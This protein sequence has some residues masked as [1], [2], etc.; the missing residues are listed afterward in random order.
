MIDWIRHPY[1]KWK[2]SNHSTAAKTVLINSSL[3]SIP[4]YHLSIYP[5]PYSSFDE[6]SKIGSNFFWSKSSNRKASTLLVGII[7]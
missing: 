1:S 7:L 5:I 4:T 3:L 2:E 6:I